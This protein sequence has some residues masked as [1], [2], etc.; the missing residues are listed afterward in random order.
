MCRPSDAR[1]YRAAL[2]FGHLFA[3]QPPG[4]APTSTL[5]N[6]KSRPQRPTASTEKSA[7]IADKNP[8]DFGPRNCRPNVTC[9]ADRFGRAQPSGR[10]VDI[11]PTGGHVYG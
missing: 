9:P 8:N 6:A 1:Q 7:H 3:E 5:Q 4:A 2:H 10:A 11:R